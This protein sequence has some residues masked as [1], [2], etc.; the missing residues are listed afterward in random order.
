MSVT[1]CESIFT[2]V[3][4]NRKS[5]GGK[6]DQYDAPEDMISIERLLKLFSYH[7][8]YN[9]VT[10]IFKKNYHEGHN[11]EEVAKKIKAQIESKEFKMI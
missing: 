2:M 9:K 7:Q 1:E 8:I 11:I 5:S 6:T 3:S 10:H 4:T